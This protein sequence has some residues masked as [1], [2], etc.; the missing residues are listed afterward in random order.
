MPSDLMMESVRP[1]LGNLVDAAA[2][3]VSP[4]LH[5]PLI[6][7]GFHG[8]DGSGSQLSMPIQRFQTM[9]RRLA[10]EGFQGISIGAWMAGAVTEGDPVI[11]TFDDGF[12]SVHAE[13]LPELERHGFTATVFPITAGLG[14]LIDWRVGGRPL[15]GLKLLEASQLRELVASGW[16][17]GAHTVHHEHLPSLDISS[18]EAEVAGSRRML[19][20]LLGRPVDSFAYPYGA[21]TREIAEIV[22]ES[23]FTSAWTT[24]PGRVSDRR[25]LTLPRYMMPPRATFTSVRAALGGTLP[26]LH[27]VLAGMERSLGRQPHNQGFDPGT[28][29]NRFVADRQP[30]AGQ[31]RSRSG[32]G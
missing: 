12:E 23:G 15:P 14:S 16:E 17:L 27:W 30:Q 22:A 2:A 11:L 10:A 1:R 4:R 18:V 6:C 3:A 5:P 8:V 19:E 20:D 9:M 21:W 28:V 32:V 25:L 13:A 26:A 31:T 7:L 24:G 29:C